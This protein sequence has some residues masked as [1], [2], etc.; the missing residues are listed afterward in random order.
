MSTEIMSQETASD[1]WQ[2][3]IELR[4]SSKKGKIKK[5]IKLVSQ[6]L[7]QRTDSPP[8]STKLNTFI[9]D[10]YHLDIKEHD[11]AIPYYQKAIQEDKNDPWASVML[12]EVYIIKK[13][14]Q[15]AIDLLKT[16]LD[17]GITSSNIR[18]IANDNLKKAVALNQK[19]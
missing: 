3:A 15:T 13:E 5:A 11:K 16:T 19:S 14:Y 6:I 10:C 17:H 2:Q 18:D 8:I 1:L 7:N 9:G 4:T 12:A